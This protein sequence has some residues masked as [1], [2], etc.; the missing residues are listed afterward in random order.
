MTRRSGLGDSG[1]GEEVE[2]NTKP[3]AIIGDVEEKPIDDKRDVLPTG[4]PGRSLNDERSDMAKREMG[5]ANSQWI[6]K[7]MPVKKMFF[8]QTVV[9]KKMTFTRGN[10][11]LIYRGNRCM[12]TAPFLC[13]TDS[14]D[15]NQAWAEFETHAFFGKNL[16]WWPWERAST[17]ITYIPIKKTEDYMDTLNGDGFMMKFD[18]VSMSQLPMYVRYSKAKMAEIET[19]N[20]FI[21][22]ALL[23]KQRL[24]KLEKPKANWMFIGTII[25][26]LVVIAGIVGFFIVFPNALPQLMNWI[27]GSTSKLLPSGM[28]APTS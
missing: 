4:R 12:R 27:S 20:R 22:Q 19:D 11:G 21:A 18:E 23:L 1:R 8:G 10:Q 26:V 2:D 28:P 3:E 5:Y 24:Q 16:S 6:D 17:K 25:I 13:K 7:P 9:A 15:S 14:N